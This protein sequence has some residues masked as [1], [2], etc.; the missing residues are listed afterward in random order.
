MG[1]VIFNAEYFMCRKSEVM[2][3]R[4]KFVIAHELTHVFDMVRLLV[5]AFKN[6]RKFWRN[7][8]EEG[9]RCEDAAR[10]YA[11]HGTFVDDY[12]SENE[13]AMVM[14]YWPSRAEEWFAAC[15]GN[16]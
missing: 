9:L 2:T 1:E 15:K 13:L 5:P 4:L 14:Q 10:F 8:L 12:G 6:W 16:L 3:K 11:L 7:V